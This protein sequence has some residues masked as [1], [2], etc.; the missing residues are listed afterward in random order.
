MVGLDLAARSKMNPAPQVSVVCAVFNAPESAAKTIESVLNQQG[1]ELELVLIDDG[2]NVLTKTVLK[3]YENDS[4]VRILE[5]ENQGLT[6]SLIRGCEAARAEYIARIDVG[7]EM[8]THRLAMQKEVLTEHLSTALVCSPVLMCAPRGE[9]LY[10]VKYSVAELVQGIQNPLAEGAMTPFHSSVMFRKNTYQQVGGYRAE[11]YLAQDLDLWSRMLEVSDIAVVPQVLTK[12]VYNI[13]GLSAR[14]SKEQQAL[15]ELV[16]EL[17]MARAKGQ[18]E[19]PLLDRIKR[20]NF[21]SSKQSKSLFAG[22]YFV[23]KC[24]LDRRSKAALSYLTRAWLSKPWSSKACGAMVYAVMLNLMGRLSVKGE[25]DESI[26][27]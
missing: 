13:D 6:K 11:F 9:A 7:D 4:R 5:Q 18:P 10:E 16:L 8:L 17:S 20:L 19:Q 26:G 1:V 27:S 15:R 22:Y 24:L 2:S 23:G 12:A 14:Y 3:A 25:F 21:S